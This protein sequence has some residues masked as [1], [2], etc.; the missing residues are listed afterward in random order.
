[1]Q[2]DA[3]PRLSDEERDALDGGYI[4]MA[5]VP[6]S[7]L[8]IDDL[9]AQRIDALNAMRV[10]GDDLQA[11][12]VASRREADLAAQ[13]RRMRHARIPTFLYSNPETC[14]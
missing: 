7:N 12:A 10:A 14:R 5:G 1:M 8:S 3:L 9:I 2:I 11:F 6:A 4:A 13:I